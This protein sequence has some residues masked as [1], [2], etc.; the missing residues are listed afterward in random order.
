VDDVEKKRF[1]TLPILNSDPSVVQPLAIPTAL[2]E[3]IVK[4]DLG[5]KQFVKT[6]P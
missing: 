2:G 6:L 1:L 5:E 4:M 3:D